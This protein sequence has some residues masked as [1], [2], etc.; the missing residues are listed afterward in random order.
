MSEI[1]QQKE[2]LIT[3]YR[4]GEPPQISVNSGNNLILESE[5]SLIPLE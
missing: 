5:I 3:P 2:R 4:N 1:A